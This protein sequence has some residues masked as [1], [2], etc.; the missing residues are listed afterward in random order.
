MSKRLNI[1]LCLKEGEKFE[2]KKYFQS[3]RDTTGRLA[4][5]SQEYFRMQKRTSTRNR[6]GGF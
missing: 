4:L 6:K 3:P 1:N 2:G 5:A